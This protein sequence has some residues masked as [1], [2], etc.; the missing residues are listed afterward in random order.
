MKDAHRFAVHSKDVIENYPLQTY[1]S[2]LV[3]SP[4]GSLIRTAFQHE[5]PNWITIKPAVSEA[6]SLCLHTFEQR[7]NAVAFSRDSNQL[8]LAFYDGAIRIW[9]ADS[10]TYLP[11]LQGQESHSRSMYTVRFFHDSARLAARSEYDRM[12]KVWDVATGACLST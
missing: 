10:S 12:I 8:A 5:E 11:E 1:V 2:A 4:S 9:D 3:F 6:W 7:C